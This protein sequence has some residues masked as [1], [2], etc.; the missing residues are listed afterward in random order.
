MNDIKDKI[1]PFLQNYV[2][3]ITKKSGGKNQYVCPF[4]NSGTGKNHSG[5]FTVYPDTYTYYCFV[6]QQ[7]GDIFNLYGALN[8]ISDFKTVLDELSRKYGIVT[9]TE[10]SKKD[11]TKFFAFAES[12]LH[13]TD[14]LTRRGISMETQRN[15]RCGYVP[16]FRHENNR[17]TPAVIIPTSNNSFFW[18]ST[19]ED[20]KRKRGTAHIL[21]ANALNN[22]YC[23]VVEGEIDC[24]SI[25]ECGFACIGLGSTNNVRKIFDCN[26]SKTVLIIAMDDDPSGKKAVGDLERLCIE[27]RTAFITAPP[28][29]WN[30]CNDANEALV[31]DRKKLTENLYNFVRRAENFDRAEY[32]ERL[33]KIAPPELCEPEQWGQPESFENLK[34]P[35]PFPMHNLPPLLRDYLQAVSDYVQVV[36]EMA[37]LPMLSVLSLCVQGKAIIMK[38]GDDGYTQPLNIY[39][40][41]VASPG[42]RKSG[43]LKEFMKPVEDFQERYNK[44]HAPEI[45]EYNAERAFWEN[46]KAKALKTDLQTAKDCAKKLAGLENKHELVLNVNDATPEAL[47]MEMYRQGGKIGIIDDE[48][49]IF[50][51]LSGIYSS[52]P[53]NINIFLKAYDAEDYTVLRRTKEDIELKKPLLTMGLMVQPEH[54]ADAMNNR[55]FSGR[56]FIYRFLFSFPES[57]AG[58]LK[59]NSPSIPPQLRK[60][61]GDL[62]NRLLRM[63][64]PP[65]IPVIQC[66]KEAELLFSDYFEHLQ[67]EIRNGGIFEDMSEWAL[68]QFS[69]ALRIAGILHLCEHEPAERLT[70]QTAMNA[71]GIATWSES[72]AFNALSD[73]ASEPTE[74]KNAKY[75][76]KKLKKSEKD[77]LS[78]HELLRLCQTLR[79]YEFDAP[80]EILEDMNYIKRQKIFRSGGGNPKEIIKINPFINLQKS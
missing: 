17:T 61:Y 34:K 21:N 1:K 51:I 78:K 2:Q 77:I 32:L 79:A 50:D 18:R 47:A 22:N 5:A 10:T 40:I 54:F 72:H 4:C 69:K 26:T 80:L 58:Y 24:L 9:P 11:Y 68:K 3:E 29:I 55:Q 74:I 28:D 59:M 36:P 66:D 25:T 38:P 65:E 20:L 63:P 52:G 48:G 31:T 15:F 45:E 49:C 41:T 8:N 43:S 35:L 12:N 60:Q 37:I 27:H 6:C 30:N 33:K 70:G 14:Y 53:V 75:I 44:I 71:I 13:K 76:L 56:G 62:I 67:K 42:E 64:V 57:R 16:D 46:K 19:T 7:S 39:T 73:S 23:F